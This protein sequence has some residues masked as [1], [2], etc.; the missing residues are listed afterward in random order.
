MRRYYISALLV[1]ASPCILAVLVLVSWAPTTVLKLMGSYL[2]FVVAGFI[3]V[4]FCLDAQ[5]PSLSAAQ[6]SFPPS[7]EPPPPSAAAA[8]ESNAQKQQLKVINATP[9]APVYD[10][11]QGRNYVFGVKQRRILGR[12]R[13]HAPNCDK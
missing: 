1:S 11:F 12:L 6:S 9:L 8:A 2:V 3:L 4:L 7:P 10:R 13:G 5:P